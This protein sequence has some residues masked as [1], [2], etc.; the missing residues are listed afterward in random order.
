[1]LKFLGYD[2]NLENIVTT[3]IINNEEKYFVKSNLTNKHVPNFL[4]DKKIE[5]VDFNTLMLGLKLVTDYLEKSIFAP[6][7]INHP[8]PRINFI[9]I[10][11]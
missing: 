2:L 5:N 6:N 3:E 9:S 1:L 8:Y 7:N 4:I 10:L 11:K